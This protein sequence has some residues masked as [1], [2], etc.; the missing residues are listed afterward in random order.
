MRVRQAAARSVEAHRGIRKVTCTSPVVDTMLRE[1][2]EQQQHTDYTETTTL[3]STSARIYPEAG[4]NR[5]TTMRRSALFSAFLLMLVGGACAVVD[6]G[7]DPHEVGL[8]ITNGTCDGAVCSP[9]RVR[10]FPDNQPHTPGGPWS[11]DLGVI[12]TRT[13]CLAL[14]ASREFRVTAVPSGETTV[15][16]WDTSKGVSLGAQ[17]PAEQ[18]FFAH[19]TTASFVP[20]DA[21]GWSV[22]LPGTSA[23]VP[24]ARCTPES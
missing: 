19:S 15:W 5:G 1:H 9:I 12:S 18:G 16:Y 21:E 13:A 14:P 2:L 3:D 6:Q 10:A 11:F 17:D 20:A 22:S 24:S 7:E 4:S 23:A 8:L